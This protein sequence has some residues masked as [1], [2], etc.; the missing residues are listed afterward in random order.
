MSTCLNLLIGKRI[1]QAREERKLSQ[2]K[3]GEP[4]DVTF[5][6][7]Q[8]YER[9]VNRVSCENMVVIAQTLDYPLTW[10]FQDIENLRLA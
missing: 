7:V 8:K 2:G 3:L 4:L 6:Q 9:G 1:R 10:F 5:Q